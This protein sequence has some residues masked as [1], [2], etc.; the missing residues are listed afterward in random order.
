MC[1]GKVEFVFGQLS[2]FFSFVEKTNV[3]LIANL[4]VDNPYGGML[5]YKYDREKEER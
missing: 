5:Q 3:F 4:F 2:D 1:H